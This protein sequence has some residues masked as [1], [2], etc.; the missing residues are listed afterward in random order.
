MSIAR[1][2]SLTTIYLAA[3]YCVVGLTGESLHYLITDPGVFWASSESAQTVVYYHTHGPD[4]HGHFH[5]HTH[6][7]HHSHIT[8][9]ASH[10]ARH[11]EKSAAVSTYQ[12]VHQPHAC[13]LLALVST[14]K[15][16]SAAGVAANINPDSLITRPCEIGVFFALDSAL[17][18]FVRGP[19][20][21]FFA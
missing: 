2:H 21:S 5:R 15:L 7:E 3:L 19:P 12:I 13:P 17:Y 16:G 14:L 9:L 20:G 8:N 4:Y 6:H 10:G 11:A 18:S 1:L